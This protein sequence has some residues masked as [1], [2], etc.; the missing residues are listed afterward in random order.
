LNALTFSIDC[1]KILAPCMIFFSF[2]LLKIIVSPWLSWED[3][4]MYI[5]IEP[6]TVSCPNFFWK[7]FLLTSEHK[8]ILIEGRSRRIFCLPSF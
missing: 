8:C 6:K 2:H 1:C 5:F 4:R 3:R 7:L